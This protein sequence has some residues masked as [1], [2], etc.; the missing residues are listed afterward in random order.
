[1]LEQN[2]ALKKLT[3]VEAGA[4]DEMPFQQ[5]VGLLE[6]G[7]HFF[8]VHDACSGHGQWFCGFTL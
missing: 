1:M 5:C 4:E 3:A 6:K 8:G 2:R 7:D